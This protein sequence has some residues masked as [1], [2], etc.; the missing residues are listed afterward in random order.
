M[1]DHDL[2]WKTQQFEERKTSQAR[3]IHEDAQKILEAAPTEDHDLDWKKQQI[4]ER[5]AS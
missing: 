3:K 1:E 5:K 4:E 2:D